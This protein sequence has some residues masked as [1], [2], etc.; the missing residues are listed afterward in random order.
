MQHSGVRVC[1]VR[2][3]KSKTWKIYKIGELH[4]I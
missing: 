1:D 3:L 4:E 2:C